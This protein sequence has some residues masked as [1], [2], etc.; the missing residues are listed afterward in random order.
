MTKATK[1]TKINR[2]EL[3]GWGGMAGGQLSIVLV[4]PMELTYDD[5]GAV[6]VSARGDVVGPAYALR[7]LG[8][9]CYEP[10]RTREEIDRVQG[11]EGHKATAPLHKANKATSVAFLRRLKAV[12]G[13]IRANEDDVTR[14]DDAVRKHAVLPKG[15][16]LLTHLSQI[17]LAG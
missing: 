4:G 10:A 12:D 14:R 9:E 16:K 11:R 13:N 7:G 2:L 6:I 8:A 3:G 5:H 15:F 17:R 1:P